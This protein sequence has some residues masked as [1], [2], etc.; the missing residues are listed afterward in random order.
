MGIS[1]HPE[2]HWLGIL[3]Y[4]I[5]IQFQIIYII[6]NK[7]MIQ[8]VFLL[9]CYNRIIIIFLFSDTLAQ[10]DTFLV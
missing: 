9:N 6:Q 8:H 2:I 3:M 4:E 10:K 7:L 5:R 1:L